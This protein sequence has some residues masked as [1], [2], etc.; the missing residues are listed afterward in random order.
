MLK[1]ASADSSNALRFAFIL[2]MSW[3]ACAKWTALA[4]QVFG[5]IECLICKVIVCLFCSHSSCYCTMHFYFLSVQSSYPIF[6]FIPASYIDT[7]SIHCFTHKGVRTAMIFVLVVAVCWNERH[8]DGIEDCWLELFLVKYLNTITQGFT[9][10]L[11]SL[12]C[13]SK[14]VECL[15]RV[16]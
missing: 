3:F 15:C 14:L 12:L 6:L 1:S 8:D 4:R 16:H 10:V 9:K 7:K 5:G 2:A 13:Y 11:V